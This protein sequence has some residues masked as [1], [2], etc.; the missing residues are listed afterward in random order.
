M[1][2]PPFAT[3]N[4]FASSSILRGLL[5]G[6]AHVTSHSE[7]HDAIHRAPCDSE[8]VADFRGRMLAAFV[9]CYEVPFQ[10]GGELGLLVAGFALVLGD[11]YAFVGPG[12]G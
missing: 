5:S 1:I 8:E 7:L 6:Q 9:Q 11:L 4:L 3:N 2:S 12:G 10:G